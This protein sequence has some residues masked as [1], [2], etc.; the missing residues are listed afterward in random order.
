M[1]KE[2]KE[3][4]VKRR[5]RGKTRKLIRVVEGEKRGKKDKARKRREIEKK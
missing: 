3:I 5:I 4:Y 2:Q 1:K